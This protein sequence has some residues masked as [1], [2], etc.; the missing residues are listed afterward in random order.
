MHDGLT[1]EEFFFLKVDE[2]RLRTNMKY[3][4]N[5]ALEQF[6]SEQGFIASTTKLAFSD[7]VKGQL[8]D[9]YEYLLKQGVNFILEAPG[10]MTLDDCMKASLKEHISDSFREYIYK[11]EEEK[12]YLAEKHRQAQEKLKQEQAERVRIV[13]EVERQQQAERARKTEIKLQQQAERLRNEQKDFIPISNAIIHNIASLV[14]GNNAVYKDVVS[15]GFD[16]ETATINMYIQWKFIWK[17]N[18]V[19]TPGGRSDSP[20]FGDSLSKFNAHTE[21]LKAKIIDDRY[22]ANFLD[23]TKAKGEAGMLSAQTSEHTIHKSNYFSYHY[24]CNNCSASGTVRC[25]GCGGSGRNNC[26]VCGGGGQ[27]VYLEPVTSSNGLPNG[28]VTR[29]RAC[30]GCGGGCTVSCYSCGGSGKRRCGSCDGHRWFMMSRQVLLI[31]QPTYSLSVSGNLEQTALRDNILKN[32]NVDSIY[33]LTSYS[34]SRST[35]AN[36]TFIYNG[37]VKVLRQ[38]FSIKSLSY[39]VYTYSN[40]PTIFLTAHFFNDLF[41]KQIQSAHNLTNSKIVEDTLLRKHLSELHA[42][43]LLTKSIKT[44]VNNRR[45]NNQD[46]SQIIVNDCNGHISRDAAN[47]LS[48]SINTM[49]KSVS[50]LFHN[51]VWQLGTGLA[52]IF[53]IWRALTIPMDFQDFIASTFITF[54]IIG[55]ISWFAMAISEF[56]IERR[57]KKFSFQHSVK[58]NNT[59]P[60]KRL[61]KFSLIA[62]VIGVALLLFK[63]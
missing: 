62:Y 56:L 14:D 57:A 13:A 12:V 7:I 63:N 43:P 28:S 22:I 6:F 50:P 1:S 45:S 27:E 5:L 44:I 42:T 47:L 59:E 30:P 58:T 52:V 41:D 29:Y 24:D 3:H 49:L 48:S 17:N 34:V 26:R 51:T 46:N 18:D 54:A 16:A 35:T 11:L 36:N 32:L 10:K 60:F 19:K 55:A 23:S 40:P 9:Q 53:A 21:A 25:G 2:E 8:R 31:G 15:T 33:R 61:I 39:N 20:Y 38:G 4:I 37:P